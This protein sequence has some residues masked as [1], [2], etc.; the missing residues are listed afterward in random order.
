MADN[1]FSGARALV[2]FGEDAIAHATECDGG[3]N[4]TWAPI[5]VLNR[6]AARGHSPVMYTASMRATR[7]SIESDSLRAIGNG[8]IFPKIGASEEEFMKNALALADDLFIQVVDT[9]TQQTIFKLEQAKAESRSWRVVAN[10]IIYED[11]SFVGVYMR[12]FSEAA[13]NATA[14]TRI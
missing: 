14:D 1:V 11:V 5:F 9:V 7:V 10:Q 12:D 3:D 2:Y 13:A 4:L 6:L 8:G